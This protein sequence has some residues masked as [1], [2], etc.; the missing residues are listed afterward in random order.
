MGEMPRGVPRT[1]MGNQYDAAVGFRWA[2]ARS[3]VDGIELVRGPV[4]AYSRSPMLLI[5][6]R[7]G[8]RRWM[9]IGLCELI[10]PPD[11]TLDDLAAAVIAEG[12]GCG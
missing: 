1:V 12:G 6:G 4:L 10:D 2:V 11:P 8:V 9:G 7:D 3:M 5:E